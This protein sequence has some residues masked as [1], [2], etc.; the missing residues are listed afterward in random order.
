MTEKLFGSKLRAK[1]LGWFFTHV[2]ERFFVR[3][4]ESLLHQDPTNLSRELARLENLR[5][6]RERK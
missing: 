4:L 5:I 2:D 1:V 3:Q 6:L